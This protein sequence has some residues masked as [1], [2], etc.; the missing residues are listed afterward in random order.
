[1]KKKLIT[2]ALVFFV[3]VV[4][5]V[6]GG[7]FYGRSQLPSLAEKV[8][9]AL[10]ENDIQFLYSEVTVPQTGLRLDF[11]KLQVKGKALPYFLESQGASVGIALSFSLSPVKV[12]LRLKEPVVTKNLKRVESPPSS[13]APKAPPAIAGLLLP[14]L[15]IETG[16][17]NANVPEF[18][19]QDL[20]FLVHTYGIKLGPGGVR[21][22][23]TQYKILLA[24][25][26]PYP[27]L[28][29]IEWTGRAKYS[30]PIVETND[31]EMKVGPIE[32][33]FF[34]SASLE[35]QSWQ[36]GLTIPK[37][38]LGKISPLLVSQSLGMLKSISGQMAIDLSLQGVGKEIKIES[39]AGDLFLN[40]VTANVTHPMVSGPIFA[41]SALEFGKD[42]SV[43]SATGSFDLNL[44]ETQIRYETLFLKPPKVPLNF[45]AKLSGNSK[46]IKIDEAK[47]NMH[48]L[49]ATATG[50]IAS[51][52]SG[53]SNIHLAVPTTD[54]AGWERF[55]P[56]YS[57]A[58]T[59]GTVSITLDYNGPTLNWKAAETSLALKATQVRFPMLRAWIPNK[60]L[61]VEG[62]ASFN[63][64][65]EVQIA[66]GALKKLRTH[67]VADF[68]QNRIQ[69]AK[70]FLKPVKTPLTAELKVSSTPEKATIEQ[71]VL[72]LASA[73]ATLS[74]VIKN[75][76]TPELDLRFHTSPIVPSQ[77]L[78]L[79]SF[80]GTSP[81]SN[82]RGSAQ[83]E[84]TVTGKMDILRSI[85]PNVN[86][87]L[88]MNDLGLNYY[89]ES[90]QHTYKLTQLKGVLYF[91]DHSVGAKEIQIAFPKS[92]GKLEFD[93]PSFNPPTGKFSLAASKLSLSDF[94]T[95][96]AGQPTGPTLI[97]IPVKSS[98][99][100]KQEDWR[101][102]PA[103]KGA[104]I[105]GKAT[106]AQMDLGWGIGKNVVVAMD[107]DELD[108]KI[109]P[110]KMEILGG[111][112]ESQTHWNGKPKIPTTDFELKVANV[113]ANAFI[114]G[115]S[116]KYRDV[117][118]GK[119]STD[120]Q[121]KFSGMEKEE[122]MDSVKGQG[123]YS[124]K[125]GQIKTM[126]LSQKP[127]EALRA[128]PGLGSQIKKTAWDEKIQQ[129]QGTFQISD[130]KIT[131]SNLMVLSPAFDAK[132]TELVIGFDQT[133]RA[134]FEW[135][136]KGN[137]LPKDAMDALKDS[138]G[139]P[140]IPITVSGSVFSPGV[141]VD[142]KWLLS[143]L[144]NYA[145]KKAASQIL[146]P[147]NLEQNLKKQFKGF[148]K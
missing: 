38:D 51:N 119:L 57:E 58:K 4:A 98:P 34:G 143:K 115:F 109:F 83:L 96:A 26:A 108:L 100:G 46:T 1:M 60:E 10:A 49:V 91:T 92:Q 6:I 140:T 11:S 2:L 8:K 137:L 82:L 39:L 20:S 44:N 81:L 12:F 129:T 17:T 132:S 87:K 31:N 93:F 47:A 63:S 3:L 122:I 9:T 127:L 59:Q 112:L 52:P 61:Q 114:Q 97:A 84:G 128:I 68:T 133:I 19:V 88:S 135:V 102:L 43:F 65:T 116:P 73:K 147:G 15:Q 75:L 90:L 72:Q 101:T 76:Q 53:N 144:G 18:G 123:N 45:M 16:V 95:Q 41:N 66:G 89:M 50:A 28:E 107:Y 138:K 33:G 70:L 22:V 145:V 32:L 54:L 27:G 40:Q 99:T 80:Q 106:A 77:I 134:K 37:T 126:N 48:N 94:Y 121:L 142:Q 131:F 23:K 130:K 42:T 120:M 136:P 146:G 79:G 25:I 69:Y 103:A 21:G 62:L 141:S 125:D 85:Y 86:G 30:H 14:F 56:K 139:V 104:R 67:S 71:G 113:D 7:Y 105:S 78:S 117:L 64:D 74:G 35:D 24:R 55:F 111:T 13:E 124:L 110:F 148:F 5:G 118:F 36:A 29:N